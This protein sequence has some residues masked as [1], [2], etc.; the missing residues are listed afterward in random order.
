M[1]SMAALTGGRHLFLTDDSGIG[2]EHKEPTIPCYVVT[3]LNDLM[4]RVISSHV[5]GERVE[6]VDENIIRTTGEY[7]N[8]VCQ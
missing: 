2:G 1:R 3:P 7:V 8:G 4:V 5:L 6:A